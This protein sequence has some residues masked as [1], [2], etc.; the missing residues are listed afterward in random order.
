M[1]YTGFITSL[2]V[3]HL[4]E[5]LSTFYMW[6]T[7]WRKNQTENLTWLL[8]ISSVSRNEAHICTIAIN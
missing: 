7:A 1:G 3:D 8:F 5:S 2:F 4:I 6:Q